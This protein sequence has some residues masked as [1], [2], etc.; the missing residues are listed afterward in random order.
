MGV[1]TR[2]WLLY[3]LAR[4]WLLNFLA[5]ICG[6]RR[7]NEP[8]RLLDTGP[9][10]TGKT[11]PDGVPESTRNP[12]IQLNE[13]FVAAVAC[14]SLTGAVAAMLGSSRT[15]RD[16][17]SGPV[18]GRNGDI[19]R[20]FP[21]DLHHGFEYMSTRSK[22][23]VLINRAWLVRLDRC[24]PCPDS[25]QIPHRTEMT[26]CAD[27]VVCRSRLLRIGPLCRSVGSCGFDAR[28]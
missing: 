7:S 1:L 10:R 8:G 17:N 21:M 9:G 15:W 18:S 23:R 19:G 26:R 16:V 28:P 5:G 11:N 12:G 13:R 22:G 24:P 4:W 27:F 3:L 14:G 6:S 2:C 25:D 20:A